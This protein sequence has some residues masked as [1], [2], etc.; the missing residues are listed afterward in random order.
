[1]KSPNLQLLY[2][3]SLEQEN[4]IRALEGKP[5]ISRADYDTVQLARL[6]AIIDEQELS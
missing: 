3:L 2:E 5:E 1:M 4:R 6:R